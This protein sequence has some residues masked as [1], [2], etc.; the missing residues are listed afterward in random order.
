[1]FSLLLSTVAMAQQDSLPVKGLIPID[2]LLIKVKA[3]TS[4]FK[5]DTS[6]AVIVDTSKVDTI[7]LDNPMNVVKLTLD[8]ASAYGFMGLSYERVVG[9]RGSTLLKVE[10]LGTYNPFSNMGFISRTYDNTNSISGIGFTPEIRYHGSERYSPLG[11]FFGFYIPLKFAS[12]KVPASLPGLPSFTVP[13]QDLKYSLVGCGVDLGYQHIFNK[14][15]SLEALAGIA[16]GKGVF[17]ERYYTSTY[18]ING[19][20]IEQKIVLKDG[21]VGNAY[22]PRLEIAAGWAF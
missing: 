22:Y 13:K 14:R 5:A 4:K 10:L 15:F 21:T 2:S 19:I 17:S 7:Y 11:L 3:D 8:V 16:I 6:R 9:F 1:M 18:T 20:P 12:V